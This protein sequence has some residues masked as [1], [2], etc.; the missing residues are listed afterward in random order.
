MAKHSDL[1]GES[2]PSFAP[3]DPGRATTLAQPAQE[4]ATPERSYSDRGA[5]E[6]MSEIAGS[7]DQ[8]RRGTIDEAR[9]QAR[10]LASEAKEQAAEVAGQAKQHTSTLM[11][12][13]KHRAADRLGNFAGA[14][15]EAAQKLGS[16]DLGSRAGYYARRAAGQLDSLSSYVR[17]AELH[18]FVS[19]AGQLARRRPEIF[20]GGAFLTGLLAAR[21]LKASSS[22]PKMPT[23]GR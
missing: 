22:Q 16:D 7:E 6:C 4:S 1:G 13:Q 23:G 17:T 2:R 10:N 15:R 12:E 21:F 8:G 19:D 18:S 11:T 20:I 3:A 14:L 5:S 9:D